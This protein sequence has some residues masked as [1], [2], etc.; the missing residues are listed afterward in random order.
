MNSKTYLLTPLLILLLLL[1]GCNRKQIVIGASFSGN[2]KWSQQLFKEIEVASY[3]HPNVG[4]D[5]LNA[6]QDVALQEKQMNELIDKHVDLIIFAPR[7]YDGYEQVL[8]RAKEAGIPVILIDRKMKSDD[9]TAFIGRDDKA[10]GRMMGE[11]I[12]RQHAGK[13]TY[14]LEA[15]GLPETSPAMERSEGFRQAIA[16]YPNLHIVG[17][18]THTWNTDSARNQ[19]FYYLAAHPNVHF[20]VVFAQSDNSALGVRDAIIKAGRN[21]GV[22]YYGVDGLPTKTGGLEMVRKG[23]FKATIINPTRGYAVMDL[24][25]RILQGKPYDKDNIITTSIVDKS[26]IDVVET[27]CKMNKDQM[28]V[29]MKQNSLILDFYKEHDRMQIYVILNVFIFIFIVLSIFLYRRVSKLN[30]KLK[31]KE[32]C[33]RIDHMLEKEMLEGRITIDSKTQFSG[34]KMHIMSTFFE[35]VIKHA[36]DPDINTQMIADEMG[37]TLEQLTAACMSLTDRSPKEV[38]QITCDYVRKNHVKLK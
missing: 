9:Y 17:T 26:N 37:V 4:I 30:K 11:Y 18:A 3:Q 10:V 33:S 25:M 28:D 16:R 1:T 15:A 20:D 31:K 24:A 22:T 2:S 8:Q 23:V 19:C 34:S 5:I 35:A 29:L 7:V 38:V 32:L 12:A 36:Y 6:K 21:A 27:Q 13:Q 14:I